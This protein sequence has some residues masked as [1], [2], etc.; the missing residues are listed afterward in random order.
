MPEPQTLPTDYPALFGK[1]EMSWA[2][3]ETRFELLDREPDLRLLARV[4]VVPFVGD[5]CV[6][7]GFGTKGSQWGPAGGGLE[8]G[9]TYLDGLRRELREEAGARL[10]TYT[11]FGMLHCRSHAPRFRPHLPH[12]DYDCLYGY[13]DVALV[14]EPAVPETGGEGI[15]AVELLP[16]ERAVALLAANRRLWEADLYRLA[17]SLR[18]DAS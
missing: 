13:G 4:Y 3:I 8:P 16:P 10:E 18:R 14:G 6:V 1:T 11:P 5:D 17:A 7:I 15:A 9:E 2:P 12:P